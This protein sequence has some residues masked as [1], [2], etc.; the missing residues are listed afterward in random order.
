MT[1]N[2]A[3]RCPASWTVEPVE[4]ASTLTPL[5]IFP[6]A[7]AGTT[8]YRR[9]ATECA[10]EFRPVIVRLPGRET[11]LREPGFR[12]ME[13]LVSTMVP[14]LLPVLEAGPVLYGHSMGAL[15]AFEVARQASRDY[16]LEPAHLVVS[17]CSAPRTR[18]SRQIRYTL[19]DSELW[20]SVCELNGTPDEIAGN[21]TMQRLVLP[22]LRADFEVSDTYRYSP[23]PLLA[24]PIDALGGSDDQEAPVDGM[25]GWAKETTGPF[26]LHVLPGDHFFNLDPDTRM[27]A[28]LPRPELATAARGTG[29]TAVAA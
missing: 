23:A 25:P 17:G 24:C 21:V 12:H 10:R 27:S 9:L 6:H 13:S 26:R 7:G 18:T 8:P 5:V 20:Q 16:G 14:A 15:V 3:G 28:W 22:A 29:R 4:T 11:R 19:S 2:L 1:A